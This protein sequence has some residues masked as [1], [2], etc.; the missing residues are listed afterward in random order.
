[1]TTIRPTRRGVAL[2][3]V[4]FGLLL[5]GLLA[6]TAQ[7]F[8]LLIPFA[9]GGVIGYWQVFRQPLPQV[10]RHGAV[11]RRA[12][13][14][15]TV[16]LAVHGS[17]RLLG[18]ITDGLPHD[19]I[20]TETRHPRR[21]SG[22]GTHTFE[23]SYERRGHYELGP[24]TVT[25]TDSIGLFERSATVTTTTAVYVYPAPVQLPGELKQALTTAHG[26]ADPLGRTEFDRLREYDRSVPLRDIDWK[27]S[28]KQPDETFIVKEFIGTQ[29]R[30]SDGITIAAAP[31]T[32]AAAD[33]V[34]SVVT[35][36]TEYLLEQDVAV[37]LQTPTAT[38][39]TDTGADHHRAID[40]HLAVLEPGVPADDEVDVA[41]TAGDDKGVTVTVFDETHTLATPT[42]TPEVSQP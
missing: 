10:D 19:G 31:K 13:S 42:S 39:S 3:I 32:T 4:S 24:T 23:L 8:V 16:E 18:T 41:V 15:V 14:S 36:L 34:A 11:S 6:N 21:I 35:A 5:V 29:R 12:G 1:M 17:P 9:V 33:H 22:P 2:G 28:A 26:D 38:L 7:V 40:E 37:G 25:L 27:T 30:S 20:G